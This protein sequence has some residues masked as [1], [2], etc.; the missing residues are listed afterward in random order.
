MTP[1]FRIGILGAAKIAGTALIEPARRTPGVEV[2]AIAA[3]DPAR[4]QA[5][6]SDNGIPR[7]E[8]DYLALVSSDVDAVYV[9]L[10]ASGHTEWA[11]RAV[12]HGKHVLV[13]KPFSVTCREAAE[14]TEAGVRAGVVVAEAMHYWYHPLMQRV[15]ELVAHA[16]LGVL[17]HVE[18]RAELGALSDAWSVYTDP[19]LGG[20]ALLHSGCYPLHFARSVAGEPEVTSARAQWRPTGVDALLEAALEF[21]N[22]VTGRVA[23]DLLHPR[24][25]MVFDARLECAGGTIAVEN[26]VVP[27]DPGLGHRLVLQPTGEEG[28]VE[29]HAGDTTYW[30]QLQAFVAAARGGAPIHTS[31]TDTVDQMRAIEAIYRAAGPLGG[32]PGADEPAG[33]AS[34]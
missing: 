34:S 28:R 32:H 4:A 31:G 1:P 22:G 25:P 17:R 29:H 24:S 3:R 7:V 26:F 10:P 33:G 5:F 23:V 21:P 18:A 9:P 11:L 8:R 19:A 13:E 14:V 2:V 20:G 30:Y 12:E 15:R 27:H 16:E 6:A